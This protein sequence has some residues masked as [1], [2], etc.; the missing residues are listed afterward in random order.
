MYTNINGV[1]G[2]FFHWTRRKINYA[3]LELEM[4]IYVYTKREFRKKREI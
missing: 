3:N 4:D 2:I 1:T